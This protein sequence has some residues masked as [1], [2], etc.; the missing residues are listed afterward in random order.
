MVSNN[1][2]S[3]DDDKG[4]RGSLSTFFQ[5]LQEII[6]HVFHD[7]VF[8]ANAGN[9]NKMYFAVHGHTA[10]ELIME[11]ADATK[12]HMGLTTWNDAPDGKILKNER[13]VS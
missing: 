9:D 12:E 3:L 5:E 7:G 2:F 8:V 6:R 1:C 13:T 11:R 4:I 10:T